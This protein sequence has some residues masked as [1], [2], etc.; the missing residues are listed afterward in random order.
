MSDSSRV[1]LAG[2]EEVTWGT[3]PSSALTAI[4]YTTES[5]AHRIEKTRSDEVRQDGQT[6]DVVPVGANVE[7]GFDLEASYS[8][9]DI[10]MEGSLRGDFSSD[11]SFSAAT[12]S[13]AASDNSFNDSATGFPSLVPGQWI[14]VAGFTGDTANNR[15]FEVVS[16]TTAKIIVTGGSLVD[17]ASGE[18]ITISDSTLVNGTT[19]KSY[20]L[21]KNMADVTQFF[22]FVGCR[23]NT[24]N[25]SLATRA[26]VTGSFSVLG[27][28]GALAGATIGSGAYDAAP[29][30]KVMNASSNVAKILEGGAVLGAGIFVQAL[31]VE[32]N[33][34]LRAVDGVSQAVAVKIG[35]GRF[36]VTGSMTVL[37]ENEVLFNKYINDTNTAINFV[38]EDAAGNGYSFAFPNVIYTDG[39]IVGSGNDDEV[40]ASME[41]EAIMHPTQGI[42]CRIDRNA[43]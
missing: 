20:S 2:I 26:K 43:A 11:S 24:F 42:T 6:T 29:T 15:W 40:L 37:F 38:I 5:L 19:L 8:A 9:H 33:S 23:I 35:L 31:D 36:T 10:Y 34:G 16:R 4:R 14:R 7:G 28:T 12:I 1:Q 18:T 27:K 17:D 25:L 41:W 22:G 13:A 32:F 39:D 21:E 3:T 30:N